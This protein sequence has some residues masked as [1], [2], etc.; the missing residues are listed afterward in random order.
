MSILDT[1]FILFKS[2]AKET[3]KDFDAL[4]KKTKQ[5][6][7]D[8]DKTDKSTRQLG[9][10]F[11]DFVKALVTAS[12]IDFSIKGLASA[13]KNVA[14]ME[15]SLGRLSKLTGIGAADIDAWD[16]ALQRFGAPAGSFEAWLSSVN[17]QYQALGQGDNVKNILPNI[18]A[19]ADKW[20]DLN[21]SQKEFYARQ[22]GLTD[23]M[24]LA[25]DKGGSSLQNLIDNLK[26]VRNITQQDTAASLELEKAWQN[27]GTQFVG[28]YHEA[29][30]IIEFFTKELE[31]L[32]LGL[33]GMIMFGKDVANGNWGDILAWGKHPATIAGGAVAP[34]AGNL[35]LGIRSNNP[36]N[37]QPGGHEAVFPTADAGLKAM[38]DQ[39]QRYG[40]RGINTVSGVVSTYAPPSANDT[41]AY[42]ADIVRQTGFGANQALNLGDPYTRS[43]LMQAMVQHENGMNPYSAGQFAAATGQK[44]TNVSIGNITINTQASDAHGLATDLNNN[45]ASQMRSAIGSFDDG[46]LW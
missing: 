7:E 12:G 22:F 34:L 13:T 28:F 39:L 31:Y 38:S 17:A 35:P 41:A 43:L 21:I 42:I 44:T 25:F 16:Q 19:L 5:T 1:F 32:A 15:V 30:P 37:L 6:Q 18:I 2:N 26:Q 23:D 27:V 11:D 40:Q 9:L 3:E 8:I 4:G 36:G 24:V 29:R 45:L 10:T 46:I 20:K 33:R 14:D